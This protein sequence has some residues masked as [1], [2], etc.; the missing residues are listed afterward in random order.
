MN[1]PATFAPDAQAAIAQRVA[2]IQRK[3]GYP[4]LPPAPADTH[5]SPVEV[6]LPLLHDAHALCEPGTT[7]ALLTVVVARSTDG[8][9]IVATRV[10]GDTLTAIAAARS[11]AKLMRA[12]MYVR[13]K[14]REWKM[15]RFPLPNG[16]Q[17]LRLVGVTDITLPPEAI[18]PAHSEPTSTAGD[19]DVDK[20]GAAA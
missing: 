1:A 3:H 9:P 12:G 5:R 19:R 10:I 18:P 8:L 16:P 7:K 14:A 4:Q 2:E 15:T 20:A 11:T 6:Y 13:I 17:M